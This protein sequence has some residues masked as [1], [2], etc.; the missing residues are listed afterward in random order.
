V[1]HDL[2]TLIP[3]PLPPAV[4]AL[5]A[6]LACGAALSPGVANSQDEEETSCLICHGSAEWF[7]ESA[8]EI[9]DQHRGSVHAAVGL[10]CHDCHGGNPDPALAEDMEAAMDPSYQPSPFL[11]APAATDVPAFCGRCHADVSYMKQFLPDPRVDQL[12]EYWTSRHGERLR[13]GDTKVATCIS[14]HGTHDILRTTNSDARVYPTRLAETCAGCHADTARMADYGIPTDQYALWRRS[15]HAQG[16]F[17][18]DDL[19]A[20]TCNDCH[21]D[22]GATPPG[23]GSIAFV[24]GQCHGREASLFRASAKQEGFRR[25][26]EYL[27]EVGEAGCQACHEA[28]EPAGH[29][30]GLSSFTECETCHGNHGIMRPSVAMLTPL[31]ETP[32]AFCHEATRESEVVIPER[33]QD[34]R[35]YEKTKRELLAQAPDLQSE[36]LFNW[37]VDRSQTLPFHTTGASQVGQSP[38]LRPEYRRLFE[39]FRIGKTRYTFASP[40]TGQSVTIDVVRCSECHADQS[41]A[42]DEPVG[43]RTAATYLERMHALTATTARAERFVLTA[44]RGGVAVSTAPLHVDKAVD[45]E[46]SLQVLVHR[47]QVGEGTEFQT[48]QQDGLAEAH[49]ALQEGQAALED[50]RVRR[51]GLRVALG[52]IVLVLI[53]LA[54]K[55]RQVG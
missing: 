48:R 39:K 9:I 43:Y 2:Q 45:A 23:V 52:V 31:P 18:Q 40:T 14:C 49:Q 1:S 19:S 13:Q 12:E 10:S 24:C 25:H 16:M 47:F 8:G 4:L 11:G 3:R 28:S 29:V 36:A 30:T 27:A 20:P 35:Q 7:G 21:G 41:A 22:H 55:I 46:I 17:E 37:L 6:T 33:S 54:L 50:M 34:L 15:V 42:T 38:Q 32:C 5:A 44:Q 51:V 26:N 53:G